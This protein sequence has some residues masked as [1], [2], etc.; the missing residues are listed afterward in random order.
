MS[1]LNATIKLFYCWGELFFVLVSLVFFVSSGLVATKQIAALSF[2]AAQG[3]ARWVLALSSA[4]LFC[5]CFGAFGAFRQTLRRGCCSGRKMLS[6]HQLLLLSVLVFGISQYEWLNKRERSMNLVI[7]DHT[8]YP[9]YD[10]FERRVSKYFNKS[11]FQSLC[12]NDPSTTW[13]LD[14]VN[15]RC[16]GRMGQEFCTLSEVAKKTCDTTCPLL[17]D[18]EVTPSAVSA[19]CPSETLCND[20]ILASCPYHRCR[21]EILE[22]LHA[23]AA[24]TK[25]A[26]QFVIALSLVMIVLSCLLICFNPRD[27]IEVELLKTGV[28]TQDDV[29]AIRRLKES[30]NV[31]TRRGT[32]ITVDQLD[33]IKES[34]KTKKSSKFGTFAKKRR[35]RVSPTSIV[36]D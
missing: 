23:W 26:S 3:T 22:E 30:A 24:P 34:Q 18:G 5:T 21:V 9:E 31:T 17:K 19:C 35:S 11:Y 10:A 15:E 36:E 1:R 7:L 25:V 16:P 28:M 12:S 8:N 20:G 13:L 6:I 2:P 29:E 27:E 4:M 33:A 32:Q 14:F